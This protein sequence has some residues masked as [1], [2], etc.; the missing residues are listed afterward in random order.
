M[1]DEVK[2]GSD[3][4]MLL[5]ADSEEISWPIFRL[6]SEYGT[7]YKTWIL[8]GIATS[9]ISP[10]ITLLPPY[11]LQT[12]IDSV[13]LQNEPFRLFALPS[14]WYPPTRIKQL[15]LIALFLGVIA[16]ASVLLEW[17][18]GWVWG[19]FSQDV[20]HT[21][22]VDTYEKAQSLELSFFESEQT[23][24]IMS[25]LNED[26]RGLNNVFSQFIG[27]AVTMT[28]TIIGVGAF[29]FILHWEFALISFIFVPAIVI[30]SRYFVRLLKPKHLEVRQRIGAVNSRIE[31]NISGM[32]VIKSYTQEEHEKERMT[33]ASKDLYDKLW[34][35]IKLRIK[36]RP[37]LGL[38]NMIGFTVILIVGGIWIVDGPPLF[39]SQQLTEGTLVAFLI[40]HQRLTDPIVESGNLIDKYYEARASALRVLTL[41]DH[42]ENIEERESTVTLDQLDGEVQFENVSYS[43]DTDEQVLKDVGLDAEAGDFIGIVGA[44]GSGKSTLLKLLLR[45]YETDEG[46]VRID[47]YDI[48]NIDPE[49]LRENIG[50]VHQN[51][52]LFSGTIRENIS[53]G[54]GDVSDEEITR[55]ARLANA[56]EFIAELPDGYDTHIGQQGTKLSG[57]QQQRIALARALVANPDILILDEAT[58]HVDNE[59][60]LLIQKSLSDVVEERTT[61]AVA[62]RL[63]TIRHAD[64]IIVL[65]DGEIVEH[66][67]H[68]ELLNQ[69]GKYSDL[70]NIHVGNIETAGALHTP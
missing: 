66:G 50:M 30:I 2:A 1:P 41:H 67:T 16:T 11:V 34:E 26:V 42:G 20:Q 32:H 40:Y 60:E 21:I 33:Q 49:S 8:F 46:T 5:T 70:W 45:F 31:N 23:G 61:F 7:N 13:L 52:Y 57:G 56:H 14:E 65:E 35:V 3:E 43:Y 9:V 12:A 62:H 69:N 63:S 58:S 17:S 29:L 27:K 37:S 48:E 68:Q 54:G 10:I 6:F 47:G 19:R 25:I 4:E 18:A 22:R 64:K 38:L 51:T 28:T 24:Q 44:T 55:A 36:F 15:Y 39:F 59:T 53:Y